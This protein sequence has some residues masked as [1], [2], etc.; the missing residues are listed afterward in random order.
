MINSYLVMGVIIRRNCTAISVAKPVGA[1]NRAS[2]KLG[3]RLLPGRRGRSLAPPPPA[4]A[5]GLL[6]L[7]LLLLVED[8]AAVKG[9]TPHAVVKLSPLTVARRVHDG[10]VHLRVAEGT[11]A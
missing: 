11:V 7:L 1:V 4:A 5:L 9:A 10:V 8:S 6:L 2:P 3:R